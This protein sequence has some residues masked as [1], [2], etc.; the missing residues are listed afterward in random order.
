M[1]FVWRFSAITSRLPVDCPPMP[2][3]GV[4][5]GRLEAVTIDQN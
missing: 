2:I 5:V 1:L 3:E 4:G